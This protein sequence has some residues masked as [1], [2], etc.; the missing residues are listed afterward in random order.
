[1][2]VVDTVGFEPGSLA[3]SVPHSS[4]V[5]VVERFTLNPGTLELVRDIV[6]EDSVYF[7]DKYVDSDSVLPAAAGRCR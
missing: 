4:K 5:H 6:T 3:S 7:A 1:V 2:I